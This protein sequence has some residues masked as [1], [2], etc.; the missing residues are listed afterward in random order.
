MSL[1]VFD[2]L[3]ARHRDSVQQ[4]VALEEAIAR[5]L[6]GD[7]HAVI[8]DRILRQLT[9]IDERTLEDCL[10]EL[11]MWR[12]LSERWFWECPVTHGTVMEA[13]SVAAFPDVIN[14]CDRCHQRH[15]FSDADT[16]VFFVA[17]PSLLRNLQDQRPSGQSPRERQAIP[18]CGEA[19]RVPSVP[20]GR[21]LYP[22]D[23]EHRQMASRGQPG[24][25]GRRYSASIGALRNP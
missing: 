7:P 13:P 11:V 19:Y 18:W 24:I 10:A 8:D 22:R 21:H 2:S 6:R 23:L 1:A 14:E 3:R 12:A 20:K 17:T 9:N 16:E 5:T 15:V 25:A 4:I